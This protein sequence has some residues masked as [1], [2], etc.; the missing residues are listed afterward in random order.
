MKLDSGTSIAHYKILSEI[1]K[2]GMGEVYRAEDT[3]LDRQIALKIL[4]K[5]FAEDIER[6]S[7]FVREAKSASA[8]NHP[9]I[10]TI[11]EI[12]KF[13]GTNYIAIEFIDGKTLGEYAKDNP[14]N[15]K[16]A[17]DIANQVASALDVAHSNGIVHRDIKPDNVMIRPD[18]F[19]KILDFG[20]AKLSEQETPEIES[21]DA[22]AVQQPSTTPGMI[23]G[24]ANYMSPEQ[25]KGEVVDARTDIFSFGVVLYE[26][27]A[28][29]LPF[30]GKTPMEIIGAVIH[31][32]PKP[33]DK[34]VPGELQRIISKTL[35]KDRDERYQTIKDLLIDL[36]D[37]KTE[38]EFQD[39][40][41]KTV[42]PEKE[43]PKTQMFKATTVDEQKQTTTANDSITIKK[44]G[45]SKALIGIF[46]ILVI[47]A[48]G[49][50]YWYFSGNKQIESIAV[51][52]FINESGN[53]DIEYLS[54]GM[55][56]TLISSLTKIPN[57]SVMARSSVFYYK[58]KKT[59][60]RQIGEELNVEAILLGRVTQRG[61][62]LKISLELVDTKTLAAIWSET[63]DRKMNNLV[64][65][66]SEIARNVSDK[67]RLK[68]TTSEQ[69]KVAVSGTASPEAQQLYLKGRFHFNKLTAG[70]Y[71]RRNIE[72]SISFYKQAIEKDSN[73]ALAYAG[74]AAS[75]SVRPLNGASSTR[76][77]LPKVKE[78]AR[79]AL[80]LDPNL[81]EA[82]AALGN[83]LFYSYDW[84][85]AERSYLKAIEVDPKYA[86]AY[87]WY[88]HLLASKRMYVEAL[89]NIDKALE[90]DPFDQAVIS[91]KNSV[92]FSA[93]KYDEAISQT[94][95]SIELFPEAHLLPW[96]LHQM[97]LAKGMEREAMEQWWILASNNQG[98]YRGASEAKIQAH[99]DIYRKRGLDRLRRI[100]LEGYLANSNPTEDQKSTLRFGIIYQFYADL[101]DK[102]KT[103]EYLNKAYEVRDPYLVWLKR[104]RRYDFLDDEPEYQELIKKIGFPEQ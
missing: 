96:L 8:L 87:H 32:E 3:K 86:K 35:R 48:I 5:E 89:R 17:L 76:E 98:Y 47:S 85:G 1:G 7:R 103:L 22:T 92:L 79:K 80:E 54:D 94:K 61:D 74:L 28:G 12:G 58:G 95:K 27:I 99:K 71:N 68:L 77:S 33:M 10:I 66:Q 37:V 73:Y 13:D 52:P 60:P 84:E 59:N 9:N 34:E 41:E 72:K 62:D 43:E 11:H 44:S 70:A 97:Y 39:K 90:L 25:A 78:A 20:I 101:K 23:I 83:I 88:G 53:E 6:M 42:S 46:A 100:V 67:L 15:Y 57:L 24:T 2:G 29:H 50:G 56:E 40:L 91:G 65:L 19:V 82:H 36:K 64:S 102:E 81:A 69:E 31:K 16:S 51:M 93:G 55:T 26:M 45:L 75:Y 4:P 104:S 14:L 49:F 30:G 21:E 38:L 63:Y 18:G